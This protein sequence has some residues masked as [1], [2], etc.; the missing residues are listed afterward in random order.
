MARGRQPLDVSASIV[1]APEGRQKLAT[2]FCR[3]SRDSTAKRL[4]PRGSRPWLVAA[5]ASAARL[6]PGLWC[7]R[8]YQLDSL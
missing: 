2:P 3:P 1:G 4:I 6:L 5:A 8:S 7:H